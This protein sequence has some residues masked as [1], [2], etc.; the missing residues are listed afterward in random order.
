MAKVSVIVLAAG[1]SRRM[2]E[3]NKLLLPW[4]GKTI[5]ETVIQTVCKLSSYQTMV[6]SSEI[7][8]PYLS[9]TDDFSLVEN[10]DYQ[11]GMTS[12]IQSG[13]KAASDDAEAY[14]IC[15]GDQPMLKKETYAAIIH[16]F[17]TMYPK[18]PETIVAPFYNGMKGNPVIF[19]A[20]YKDAILSHKE[21]EGCRSIIKQNEKH[22]SKVELTDESV[23]LDIDTPEKYQLLKKRFLGSEE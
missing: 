2:G 8:A 20:H 6:V 13:V 19:S 5:V 14:M 22:L 4:N 16:H 17:T 12:T 18:D 1:T 3:E 11:N 15:L 9:R 10:P 21:P 7:T 23:I